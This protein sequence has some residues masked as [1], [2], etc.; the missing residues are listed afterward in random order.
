MSQSYKNFEYIIVD[1]SSSDNTQKIIKSFIDKRIKF[2]EIKDN[3]IYEALNFAINK[4]KGNLIGM[5]HSGD[6]FFW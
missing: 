6:F 2:F 3:S 5:L 1:G 4:S